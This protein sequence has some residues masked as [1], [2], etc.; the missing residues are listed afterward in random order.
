VSSRPYL[1]ELELSSQALCICLVVGFAIGQ[2][3]EKP[4]GVVSAARVQLLRIRK[5]LGGVGPSTFP[6]IRCTTG[7]SVMVAKA[8]GGNQDDG[9]QCVQFN[10]C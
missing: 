6:D 9:G 4:L 8:G 1:S 5:A 7:T 2:K 3:E 10:A